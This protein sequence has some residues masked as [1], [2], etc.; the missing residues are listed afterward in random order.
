VA[1]RTA[2]CEALLECDLIPGAVPSVSGCAAEV[3]ATCMDCMTDAALADGDG[4]ALEC[5]GLE[6]ADCQ[7]CSLLIQ[8]PQTEAE[9]L[10]IIALHPNTS[11][12]YEACLCQTCIDEYATCIQDDG[13]WLV[14]QC[15]YE[16]DCRGMACYQAA[17]C[18]GLIDEV[19]VTSI[20]VALATE[21]GNC[22]APTCDPLN[23]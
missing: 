16:R 20:S 21:L 6:Q 15:M 7:A 2:L 8:P 5:A 1:T 3:D 14:A 19:G 13:C 17:L 22:S 18:M 23:D 10:E 12:S 4:G 11:A 9:C